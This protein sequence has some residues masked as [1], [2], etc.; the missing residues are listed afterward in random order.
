MASVSLPTRSPHVFEAS[1]RAPEVP[2][3]APGLGLGLSIAAHVLARHQ[4][5]DEAAPAAGGGTELIV[6]LPLAVDGG[7]ARLTQR[8]PALDR[9]SGDVDFAPVLRVRY[10]LVAGALGSDGLEL[11]VCMRGAVGAQGVRHP[12][13]WCFL[14]ML[15]ERASSSCRPCAR[16]C[17]VDRSV[18]NR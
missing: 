11:G 2:V 17:S 10:S 6:R 15:L 1:Y 9:D 18:A 16:A 14:Q 8:M 12:Q 3:Y 7:A 4:R 13:V 5:H